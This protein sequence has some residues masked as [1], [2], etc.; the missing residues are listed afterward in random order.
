MVLFE[1]LK[2]LHVS[3]AIASV[4]GFALRGYWM[5]SAA[6][7]VELRLTKILP[8]VVDTLLLGS[9]IGMLLVWGVSPFELDWLTAKISAL[10]IY[11]GLGM[12]AFRFAKKRQIKLAA[13]FGALVSAAYILTVAYT[14][15]PAGPFWMLSG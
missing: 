5:I 9:A 2:C 12:V 6:P 1:W 13:Y 10:V 11:I 8:H 3:C 14:K 7:L 4:G 15:S